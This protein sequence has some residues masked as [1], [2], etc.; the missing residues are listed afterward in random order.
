MT[1]EFYTRV[2]ERLKLKIRKFFGLR[3]TFVKVTGEKM[4]RGLFDLAPNT[5]E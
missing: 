1:L 2:A 5:E 4:A 3:I